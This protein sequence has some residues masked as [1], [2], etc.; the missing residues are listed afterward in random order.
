MEFHRPFKLYFVLS[1]LFLTFLILAELTGS[2]WIQ[3]FGFT[4]T[5]GVIPFPVTFIVTDLLN[6][7]Y[8]RRGVR[9]LTIVGMG[10]IVFAYFLI[11]LDLGIP[12][13]SNSPVDDHSFQTV[14]ANSGRVIAGSVVAYLLGQLLD[15]QVFHFLR[16]RTKNRFIW[17]RATGSTIISQLLDS[18]VVIFIAYFGQYEFETLNKISSTNFL[19]KLGIAIAITPVI[20][21]AHSLIERY[22]GEDAKKLSERALKEGKEYQQPFP[23]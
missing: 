7:Y 13:V 10:M 17:L 14:F 21:L 8:G 9:Y 5:I 19:Y 18:Y 4:M 20:Y 2:K 23:G 3:S 12:A 6:E 11:Q 1:A 16:M 22:L 15:I